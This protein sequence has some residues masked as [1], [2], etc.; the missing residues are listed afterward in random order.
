MREEGLGFIETEEPKDTRGLMS[1][2]INLEKH[3][4]FWDLR[5][6]TIQLMQNRKQ[7]IEIRLIILGLFIQKIERLKLS[8]LEQQLP[9]IMEDYLNRLDNEEFIES[10]KILK[11]T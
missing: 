9:T 11:G 7:P 4:L 5:V 3:P 10:L 8:D 2:E 1:N 6:F